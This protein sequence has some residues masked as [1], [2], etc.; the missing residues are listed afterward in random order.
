MA[1]FSVCSFLFPL[2]SSH[3]PLLLQQANFKLQTLTLLG[4]Y[5]PLSSSRNWTV[6]NHMAGAYFD[7]DLDIKQGQNLKETLPGRT[8]SGSP[9]MWTA[10]LWTAHLWTMAW[11][12]SCFAQQPCQADMAKMSPCS[13]NSIS[14]F[15]GMHRPLYYYYFK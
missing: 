2:C 8:Q 12:G 14:C 6:F 9:L 5:G 7:M 10:H 13:I 1:P 11:R 4:P 3:F 15:G